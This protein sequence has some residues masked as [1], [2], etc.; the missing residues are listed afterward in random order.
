M[1]PYTLTID[2]DTTIDSDGN[3]IFDDD[4]TTSSGGVTIT[5]DRL[6]F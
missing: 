5:G 1:S 3:G 6:I 2:P 4:F